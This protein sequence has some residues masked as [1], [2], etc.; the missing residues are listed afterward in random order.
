[1]SHPLTS[2]PAEHIWDKEEDL[3]QESRQGA[4]K[5]FLFRIEY[6]RDA[7]RALQSSS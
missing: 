1:M 4:E 7:L 6:Q 2:L 3:P 5:L